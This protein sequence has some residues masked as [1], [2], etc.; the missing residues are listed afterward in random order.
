MIFR[1]I[2]FFFFFVLMGLGISDFTNRN[3]KPEVEH[4]III[5]I[6]HNL[7]ERRW[8]HG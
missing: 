8:H 7:E 4:D 6:N 5:S 1:K 2:F 3:L